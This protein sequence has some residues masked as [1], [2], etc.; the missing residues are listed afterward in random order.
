MAIQIINIGTNPNDGTG[1]D[2]RTAFDKVNDNFAE[3]LAV[4]GETNTASNLGLGA[5]VFKEKVGLDFKFRS[6]KS[7]NANLTVAEGTNE[8]T[9]T[10]TPVPQNAFTQVGVDGGGSYVTATSSSSAFVIEGGTNISTRIDAGQPNNIII[11]AVLEVVNDPSPQL[12]GNLDLVG[13]DIVDSTGASD[14]NILG[15][16][17]SATMRA[18]LFTGDLK[19]SVFGDDSTPIIDATSNTI[20]GDV[21]G[22]LTGNVTGNLSGSLGSDLNLA[23]FGITGAGRIAYK[24]V[25]SD[26]DDIVTGGNTFV[27]Q[28]ND[29]APSAKFIISTASTDEQLNYFEIESQTTGTI[30]DGFGTGMSFNIGEGTL[31]S[32]QELAFIGARRESSTVN[33]LT[34]SAYNENLGDQVNEQLI[35]KSNNEILLGAGDPKIRIKEGLIETFG[36]SNSN[37]Q[38]NADG[39]GYVDFYGAYQFPRTIGNAGEVLKVGPSGTLLEWGTGGGGAVTSAIASATQGNPV[40]ITTTTAHGLVDQQAVTITDVGGMVELNGNTYYVDVTNSTTVSLYD[41]DTLSTTTNGTGFTAY[42]SGGFITGSAGGGSGTFVGL[43]DTPTSYAGAAA[44]ADKMVQVN[45]AGNG[46]EFTSIGSIVDATYIE[47]AGFLPKGGGTMSGNLNLGTNDITN[48]GTITA[49]TFSGSL[50]GN[51]SGTHSGDVT[52]ATNVTTTNLFVTTIDT[53]DSSAVTFTPGVTMNSF[54][55]V[56]SSLNVLDTTNTKTLTVTGNTTIGGTLTA[57]NFVLIGSGA[58][59]FSSGSD[60]N[61]DAVGQLTTNAPLVPISD[62]TITLGTASFAFSN[63]YA[64]T[65]T[66]DLTGTADLATEVTTTANNTTNETV[67]LTFVDGA[68][69]AQGI[70]TDTDLSYNPSTNILTAG[71]FNGNITATRATIGS[72]EIDSNNIEVASNGILRL[73]SQGTGYIELDGNTHVNG[74]ISY[75]NNEDINIAGTAT[76]STLSTGKY[77]SF[78]TTQNWVSVGAD[79]AYANLA[80]GTTEGQTKVIKVVSRGEFS[81]NGG[82]TFTDRYLVVNLT[83]NGGAGTLNVS[84]NSEYGA[85][86]L[87]WHNNSWWV[88]GK[89]DS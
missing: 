55:T 27:V 28:V 48:G 25:A 52:G 2:L 19:G 83:I 50:S 37:L 79:Y 15:N 74:I 86:T 8:I 11:D 5:K 60:I 73:A 65:F 70:E 45:A 81:T 36:A 38:L 71:T 84:E 46:L 29:A 32:S 35:L 64:D 10:S 42:T 76:A 30:Q 80:N 43:A 20:N 3:L 39:T 7:G 44:D 58:P 33:A 75:A 61:F 13:N 14:I 1:D 51:S 85:V 54:L 21:T 59:S 88:I 12:G 87:V 56:E 17:R 63:V 22:N 72:I 89:V 34:F 67:Y 16:I 62:G 4:G 18:N 69:G 47:A 68:T 77:V 57:D 31:E 82:A 49:T 53:S 40:V 9:L 6:I 24:A 23:G 78:V 41:D 66:G 26:P